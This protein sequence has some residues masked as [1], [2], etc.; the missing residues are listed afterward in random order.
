MSLSDLVQNPDFYPILAI[1]VCL[2]VVVIV[3]A[4]HILLLRAE[5]RKH[6]ARLFELVKENDVGRIN[7]ESQWKEQL[8]QEQIK[9][10][11]VS[12]RL[13]K[14]QQDH[15]KTLFEL[16]QL[17]ELKEEYIQER[18]SLTE[19]LAQLESERAFLEQA[20]K[21]LIKEFENSSNKIF[22][23]K[24]E[25]FTQASRVNMEAILNP[26]KDQLKDFN[27]RVEDIY[28]KENS[29][30]NQLFGQ[31]VELQKQTQK[32]SADANN[33]AKALKGDNKLQGTWGEIVLERLLEE[34]GL[35]KGREYIV[36]ETFKNVDGKRFKPDVVVHLPDGKD[37]VIDAKVSMIDFERYCSGTDTADQDKYLKAH[38]DSIRAHVKGLSL[39]EY[40]NLE[41]IRTLDFVFIFIPIEAAYIAA[42]QASPALFKEAYDKN[43]VLVSPSSLMVALRT[44]ETIW[45]Y[46]KQNTNAEA[47]AASAGKLYDQFVLFV[48]SLEDIGKH[49]DKAS[50]AYELSLKRLSQGRGNLLRRIDGLKELGAKTSKNLPE[51]IQNYLPLDND[52][53]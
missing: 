3:I 49:I 52:E 32:I 17:Q 10:A 42:M 7:L 48:E 9:T 16:S 35:V 6:E 30:R 1:I 47:I 45:R 14:V 33:L 19:K 31:I 46:E 23:L 26:F 53:A 24:Q 4:L 27:K 18:A 5:R 29:E 41:G 28:H 2:I 22:E 8:H 13:E 37:I 38:V 12:S 34:S 36:Q 15:D 51:G 21:E 44:V 50:A 25:K 43:I 40:E 39:K 11:Q 20:K